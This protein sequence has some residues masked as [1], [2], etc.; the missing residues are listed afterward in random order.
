ME[1]W[2]DEWERVEK[3]RE[4]PLVGATRSHAH[5][6]SPPL[7]VRAD[8]STTGHGPSR[9]EHEHPPEPRSSERGMAG[10]REEACAAGKAATRALQT[11]R[12]ELA[13]LQWEVAAMREV[14]SQKHSLADQVAAL[15]REVASV[16]EEAAAEQSLADEVAALRREVGS[17]REVEAQK[18]SVADDVEA[19]QWEVA[20][21]REAAAAKQS[22]ADEVA[23]L[24]QQVFRVWELA[25]VQ[26]RD[27]QQVTGE[28]EEMKREL[29]AVK[30]VIGSEEGESR[31]ILW[32]A[33]YPLFFKSCTVIPH[34]PSP[35]IPLR[36]SLS[37]HPSPPIPLRPSLS[38]HPSPHTPSP[39]KILAASQEAELELCGEASLTDAV[40]AHVAGMT[41]LS[42]L[43]LSNSSGF[44]TQGLQHLYALPSLTTLVLCGTPVGWEGDETVSLEG[45]GAAS[46]LHTLK[47]DHTSVD[48]SDLEPL[49]ALTSLTT[50]SLENCHNLTPA[51]LAHVGQL[52]GLEELSLSGCAMGDEVLPQLNCLPRLSSLTVPPGVT[53]AGLQHLAALPALRRLSLGSR[54]AR[55][56][57]EPP[58]AARLRGVSFVTRARVRL[59]ALHESTSTHRDL[60]AASGRGMAAMGKRA[61]EE[62]C[63]AG[64]AAMKALQEVRSELA[65]LQREVA[66][67]REEAF[68]QRRDVQ[69]VRGE[70]EEMKREL[71][72]VKGVIGSE[73]GESREM[74]HSVAC[75]LPTFFSN[76]ALSFRTLPLHTSLSAHPSPPIP[77]RPSLSAHPSPHTPSPQKILAASQEAELE[78]CGEASLTDAVLAHVAGMTRLS[79]LDLSNSSGFTTQGLQHLYALPSLT[80]LVLCGTPVGWEGD[81]TVSLE[82][83]GA[84]SSLE[85]LVLDNTS[86][87]DGDLEP[88]TALTSL[89]NLSLGNCHN[90]T[91][92]LL[93]HVGRLTGL[94]DLSLSGCD[95]GDDVLPQLTCL[96][97]LSMLAIPH[98]CIVAQRIVAQCIVA[99]R[100]VAQCI[101]DWVSLPVDPTLS[102]SPTLPLPSPRV[103]SSPSRSPSLLPL[104]PTADPSLKVLSAVLAAWGPFEDGKSWSPNS[105]CSTVQ[106]VTCDP[107][108]YVVSLATSGNAFWKPIPDVVSG[109]QHLTYLAIT[110]SH[111]VGSL[112]TAIFNLPL[113]RGIKLTVNHL[114]GSIPDDISKLTAL[115]YLYLAQNRLTGSLP[116]SLSHL[117]QLVS[118][119]LGV[120]GFTGSIPSALSTMSNLDLLNLHNNYFEGAIPDW[121]STIPSLM[122]IDMQQNALNGTIPASL[123]RM[124]QLTKLSLAV[125]FIEGSIP[126]ELGNLLNLQTLILETNYLSGTIPASLGALTNLLD[127][128]LA[129]TDITGTLPSSIGTLTRLNILNHLSGDVYGITSNM[130]RLVT[131]DV[132]SNQFTGRLPSPPSPYLQFYYAHRNYFSYG[133]VIPPKANR[134]FFGNAFENCLLNASRIPGDYPEQRS[135]EECAAFCGLAAGDTKPL[136]SGHGVCSFNASVQESTCTCDSN[137]DNQAGPHSCSYSVLPSTESSQT[138][139]VA[140][141][142]AAAQLFNGTIILTPPTSNTSGAAAVQAPIRLFH[143]IDSP[144]PCGTPFAFNASFSFAMKPAAA[145]DM[146]GDGVAFVVSAAAPQGAGAAGVGLGGVGKR[147]VAVEFDSMLSVKHSDPNDNHVG[148]NVGGSPVSLASATAPLILNDAHTKHAWIHYDPTSGG[149]LR[150]FLSSDPDQPPTPILRARVSLC[151]ILQPT[152]AETNFF[153][154]FAASTTDKAQ[155]NVIL[156]WEVVTG[157][158][159]RLPPNPQAHPSQ[160]IHHSTSII[161][162]PSQHIHHSTSITAHPSQHIHHSTSITA[163]PSQHIHHSTSIA[164]HPSQHVH[165][166]T[167]ITARP[168]QH[169]H[170]S[171]SITARPSLAQ[172]KLNRGAA[173][174]AH[175][176]LG[177]VLDEDSYSPQGFNSFFHYASSGFEPAQENSPS[178]NVKS[179]SIW[180]LSESIWP[181]KNQ[182]GCADSWA[183][184]VVAAV[185]AAYSIASNWTQPPILSV[186]HLRLALSSS[187]DGGSPTKAL[188]FLLNASAQ[189][190]GLLEETTYAASTKAI[191]S[192]GRKA[193]AK[194]VIKYYGIRGIERTGFYG[195]FGLMLAVQRQPVIVHIEA[196]AP[197]F[198]DYDGSDVYADEGCFTEHVNH[199]VLVVGYLVAGTESAKPDLPPPFWIIRNS[200]GSGWGD[201]GHMRMDIRSGDGICG[202]NTLPGLVPIVRNPADPCGQQSYKH[203][204]LN[205]VFN[206]CGQFSCI[207]KKTSNRCTC[208]DARF[209][210]VKNTDGS[211]TCAYV[212]VCGSSSR[213]PCV[214]GTCVNDGKGSYSCVCPRGFI[215]GTMI[216]GGF[217]CT[218]GQTQGTYTVVAGNIMCSHISAVFSMPTADL[219][220][221]GVSCA[222]PLPI[223]K[224]L[225]VVF[226]IK[227]C[228]VFYSTNAGD[229]CTGVARQVELC[230][231]AASNAA[232]EAAFQALNPAVNCSSLRPSQAV[233]IERD[234]AKANRIPVCAQYYR[235]RANDTCESIMDS[236]APPLGA[237]ELYRLNP[238]INCNQ[239]I[240]AKDH[241][242]QWPLEREICTKSATSFAIGSCPTDN[243]YYFMPTDTCTSV[244]V[245]HFHGIKGCYRKINGYECVDKMTPGTKVCLPNYNS[246][247]IGECVY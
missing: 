129:W 192:L 181:V 160:R 42:T 62:A 14:E 177:F 217:S 74:W 193:A 122:S 22:L 208:S 39:Q 168:S 53:D 13:A 136:C 179:Y 200:W 185:E 60:E 154:G 245:Q 4:G 50:L 95:M 184:A 172:P 196:S 187:C 166:S 146:G 176:A 41:R 89:T 238:G 169:I 110:S 3:G 156:K 144:G 85:T 159:P 126:G 125:N 10:A 207:K 242:F 213:N 204:D 72:A 142:G 12:G 147:S 65:A 153:F 49:T 18:H 109:L 80:T 226:N 246:A 77:L 5:R 141:A 215:Q 233:C 90:L 98:G 43:D 134:T 178:W 244:H 46:Q 35:H 202:I 164:A 170:H 76:L 247:R 111:L 97:R 25:F 232:C 143:F 84:A 219:L 28:V 212:D 139:P 241:S 30:G 151:S 82:G 236:A 132:S 120:N 189:G 40:L 79:T 131:L 48:D 199:V 216:G 2:E 56:T 38:A 225:S 211:Y 94:E 229:T 222:K 235:P 51:L 34:T 206:P 66:A 162:H 220:K 135:A 54:R 83:I 183:Y 101:I 7:T 61:R 6:L 128:E 228:S 210:E 44:T 194:P 214:V 108:G 173:H 29:A 106:G 71:A 58:V 15:Q 149:T 171:T 17:M 81:E 91:P 52:T 127:L 68:V 198:Q 158:P 19:L 197:S 78:L 23:V 64:E 102:C 121:L 150:V 114:N 73:E 123:S 37:A 175:L 191:R 16:R 107:D 137:F 155:E 133:A 113:L 223:G 24:R 227:D 112:P 174:P 55:C 186:E 36:P 221:Q 115:T 230:G 105:D 59:I 218:P 75:S 99:Q 119:N 116:E 9:S 140:V 138:T 163:H 33:P 180:R 190:K 32:H 231:V 67:V 45:I 165:H 8:T 20:S 243:Q 224:T 26:R 1:E 92:A 148:V 27:V 240:P 152:A 63:A 203:G 205:P 87:C 88:L 201:Q 145:Q 182:R 31:E 117:T 161:A 103:I 57:A 157:L 124:T 118:V 86:V 239:L 96:P 47:L 21:L 100:I 11:V 104:F 167:S 195:W 188:Q 93:V 234:P 209:A 237:M 69:R 70:V 130:T